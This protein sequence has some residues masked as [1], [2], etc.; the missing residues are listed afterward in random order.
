MSRHLRHAVDHT[1]SPGHTEN[2]FGDVMRANLNGRLYLHPRDPTKRNALRDLQR[3]GLV[4]R[5]PRTAASLG[6]WFARVP[7]SPLL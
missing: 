3:A 5:V 6:G 2:A 4:E 7:W 1:D